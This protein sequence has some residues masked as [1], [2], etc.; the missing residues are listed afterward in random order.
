MAE[1]LAHKLARVYA[2]PLGD[3]VTTRNALA[4]DLRAAGRDAALMRRLADHRQL[5]ARLVRSASTSARAL[6]E[7]WADDGWL[8]PL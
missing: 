6:L 3:F 8:H 7:Q 2:V 5:D 1:P 4:R